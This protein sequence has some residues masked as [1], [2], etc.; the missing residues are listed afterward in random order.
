MEIKQPRFQ[1]NVHA[2]L[3]KST[4]MYFQ[5]ILIV[6]IL[7]VQDLNHLYNHYGARDSVVG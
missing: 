2:V 6:K 4:Y 3:Y 5:N 1:E 7:E